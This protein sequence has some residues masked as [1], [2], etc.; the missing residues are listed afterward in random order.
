MQ[1][2]LI[3]VY[4]LSWFASVPLSN[5]KFLRYFIAPRLFH[6]KFLRVSLSPCFWYWRCI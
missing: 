6:S 2:Q 3:G 4:K 5:A 1:I